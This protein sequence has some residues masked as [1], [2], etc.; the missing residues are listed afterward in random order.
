MGKQSDYGGFL[1]S[2]APPSRLLI[3][4]PWFVKLVSGVV[5]ISGTKKNC[6]GFY[7]LPNK[8]LLIGTIIETIDRKHNRLLLVSINGFYHSFYNK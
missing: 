6:N 1:K 7:R 4:N 8:R 2:W 3:N 5:S